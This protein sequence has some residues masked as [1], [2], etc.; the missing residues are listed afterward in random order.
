M[1]KKQRLVEKSSP[2][3]QLNIIV[4]N[5]LKNFRKLKLLQLHRTQ[6]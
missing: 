4:G 1:K 2:F 5:S 6:L 3:L